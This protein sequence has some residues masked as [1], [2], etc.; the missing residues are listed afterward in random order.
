MKSVVIVAKKQIQ[1]EEL[2]LN[3][4]CVLSIITFSPVLNVRFNPKNPY[5]DWYHQPNEEEA[6]RR[7]SRRSLLF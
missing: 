6:R 4:R 7:W 2:F 5:P 3:Y 1:D